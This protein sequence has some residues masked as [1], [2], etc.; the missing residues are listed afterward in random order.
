MKRFTALIAL[1]VAML[2]AGVAVTTTAHADVVWSFTGPSVEAQAAA[3]AGAVWSPGLN[4][5]VI[6]VSSMATLAPAPAYKVPVV[7]VFRGAGVSPQY[8]A[9]PAGTTSQPNTGR[10]CAYTAT[11]FNGSVYMWNWQWKN[12]CVPVGAPYDNNVESFANGFPDQHAEL[13]S[14]AWCDINSTFETINPL[15]N[16]SNLSPYN[17]YLT[18]FLAY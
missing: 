14:N 6:E 1:T 18:S 12:Q 13:A 7:E 16:D 3:P 9:C 5:Y 17:N 2:A 8:T 15:G 10:F 11:G 4:A